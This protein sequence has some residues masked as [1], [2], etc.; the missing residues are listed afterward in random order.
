VATLALRR[1]ACKTRDRAGL[2]GLV[3]AFALRAALVAPEPPNARTKGGLLSGCI[4]EPS[5]RARSVPATPRRG[6]ASSLPRGSRREAVYADEEQVEAKL[7]RVVDEFSGEGLD[8]RLKIVEHI[9]SQPAHGIADL[10]RDVEADLIVVG[11]RGHGALSGLL[12]GSVTLRLLH[13]APCP[14]LAVPAS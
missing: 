7:K 3:A 13:V 5:P 11:T 1:P 12:L 6:R 14:V 9:G 10:A 4:R 8:A 2:A